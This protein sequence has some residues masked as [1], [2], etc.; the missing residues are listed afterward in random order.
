MISICAVTLK[1][2]W[3]REIFNYCCSRVLCNHAQWRLYISY[4]G[5]WRHLNAFHDENRRHSESKKMPC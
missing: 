4:D 1:W 3:L 5:E 2:N